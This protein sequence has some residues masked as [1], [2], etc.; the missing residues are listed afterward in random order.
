M[1]GYITIQGDTLS[2]ADKQRYQA[3]YC[4][5]CHR[6]GTEFGAA[7]RATLTYDLTF[8]S[9]LLHSL[10]PEPEQTD[11]FRCPAN[12]LRKCHY[13]ETSATGY[14]ADLNVML[15]WYKSL[16]DWN[17][18]GSLVAKSKAKLLEEPA[19]R[20][21]ERWPRQE[22]AL[23]ESLEALSKMERVGELNPD[24]P[25]NCFGQLMGELFVWREDDYTPILREM[26]AAMGRFIYLMDAAI[27]LKGDLK[28][29]RYNP[30]AGQTN[31]D[32]TPMLTMLMAECT[33]QFEQLPLEQDVT[34][35]RNILYAGAWVTY[36][37]KRGRNGVEKA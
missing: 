21:A 14:A 16:D 11:T 30:L 27:D 29:E 6:L 22:M 31:T 2:E 23:R 24:K 20:A 35:L 28:N 15:A 18:E 4:G 36:Q 19:R 10:Y 25:A 33:A 34:I 9:I 37:T 3:Y 1:F 8:L 12:P 5:L 17:D 32:F 26:G 13:L 7:G